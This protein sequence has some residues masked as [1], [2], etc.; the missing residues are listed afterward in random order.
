MSAP[1]PPPTSSLRFVIRSRGAKTLPASLTQLAD[2]QPLASAV[3]GWRAQW[4]GDGT[5]PEAA[6]RSLQKLLGTRFKVLPVEDSADGAERYPTGQ[7]IVRWRQPAADDA[8]QAL[9]Q[10]H[11]LQLVQRTRFTDR[12][13]VYRA[14]GDANLAALLPLL[15]HNPDV[16][17]AWLEVESRYQRAP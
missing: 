8:L 2:V 7:L 1:A 4:R 16:E 3:G 13:A 9:A 6:Q 10:H 17:R 5:A 12:Q 14:D 15:V 11:G